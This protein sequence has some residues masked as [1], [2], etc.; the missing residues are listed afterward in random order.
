[1]YTYYNNWQKNVFR[2]KTM[3]YQI[4]ILYHNGNEHTLTLLLNE[5]ICIIR[6]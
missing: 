5:I 4:D 2:T 6:Y 1:M 3:K